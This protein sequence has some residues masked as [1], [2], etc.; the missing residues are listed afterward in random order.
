MLGIFFA[1]KLVLVGVVKEEQLVKGTENK[2]PERIF[3]Q[4][5]VDT[6][7]TGNEI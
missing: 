2:H 4:Q 7:R 6:L 3:V 5:R 1:Y